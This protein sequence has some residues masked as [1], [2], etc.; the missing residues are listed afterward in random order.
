MGKDSRYLAFKIMKSME[1]SSVDWKKDSSRTH[2]LYIQQKDYGADNSRKKAIL[3]E[4]EEYE[5]AGYLI[6]CNWA[7]AKTDIEYIKYCDAQKELFYEIVGR[8]PKWKRV[9]TYITEI[10]ERLERTSKGWIRNFYKGMLER[11]EK[12]KIPEELEQTYTNDDY[13]KEEDME[14]AFMRSHAYDLIFQCLDALDEQETPMYKRVFS[15]KYFRD[16]KKF[17]REL[18]KKVLSLVRTF[19]REDPAIYLDDNMKDQELLPQIL[20][21][22]YGATL[23]L[24]GNLRI[25]LNEK[26]IF[27]EDWK[28]GCE[29]NSD[30]LKNAVIL[31]EQH[32]H[33]IITVENKANF[34]SMPYEDEV[35]LIFSHGYPSPLERRFLSDLY[36]VL[37]NTA[38][39]YYHTGDMDYGGVCIF[40]YIRTQIFPELQ[41]LQMDVQTYR[42]YY[43]EMGNPFG[44]NEKAGA[45][46]QEKLKQL[47]EPLLQPL[48]DE[49]AETGIGVEQECFLVR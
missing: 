18:Q 25:A 33:K 29:L 20:L 49:M 42:A 41:P 39:E 46:I 30:M 11:L 22:E 43:Q 31:P 12:G 10:R 24:K 6:K 47:R 16:S 2:T 23:N 40:R 37:K 13:P 8:I 36:Q 19:G 27:L 3:E 48:I 4:A 45:Q 7:N 1:R 32:I 38:V 17:E 26:E 5:K 28:Y 34:M 15:K 9:E 21:E 35:L 44:E 14:H